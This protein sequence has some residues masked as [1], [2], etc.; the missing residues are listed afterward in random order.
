MREY[1]VDF[2]LYAGTKIVDAESAEDAAAIV[3]G[4]S[5]ED[6]MEGSEIDEIVQ[7]V[8]EVEEEDDEEEGIEED[9]Q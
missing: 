1:Y 3:Q 8:R 4:M 7:D 9:D 5:D 2:I 6:L